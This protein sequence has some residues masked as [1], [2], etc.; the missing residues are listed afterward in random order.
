MIIRR[1]LSQQVLGATVAVAFVLTVILMSG[2]IIK[3]FGMAADGRLDVSLLTAVLVYRL[4]GF[5]ELIVPLGMFIAILLTFGRLYLDNEMAV[6]SA[7]GVSQAQVILHLAVPVVLVTAAVAG[8]S[9]YV[10]PYGNAASE[11]LFAEQAARNTFDLIKPGR[12]QPVGGRILYV[13]ELSPDKRELRDVRLFEERPSAT[14]PALQ[15]LVQAERGRREPDPV[16][17]EPFLFLEKG[18]RHELLPGSAAYRQLHFD[19]YRMRLPPPEAVETLTKIRSY[20]T[21]EIIALRATRPDAAGE[22]VWRVSMPLLVPVVA[23]LA[24][25]LS[26]VNPRQGRY[27]KLLPA[28]LLY[29]SYIVG[30]AAVRNAVEKGRLGGSE[31]W[32]VHVLYLALALLI[33]NAE[34]LRLLRRRLRSAEV[35]A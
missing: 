35:A 6:L 3:Y 12:F 22:W 27:L 8:T 11:R 5:L 34:N 31:I 30:I 16:T 24:F 13:G 1:Y 4:P 33:T 20:S 19:T 32:A 29:L 23:L 28:I 7:S 25:S 17:G 14:G 18:S 2:R 10:T 9:F 21:P 26:R 15:L